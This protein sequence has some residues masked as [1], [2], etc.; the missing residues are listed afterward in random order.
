MDP[1]ANFNPLYT[2]RE[3]ARQIED[4]GATIMV[5]CGCLEEAQGERSTRALT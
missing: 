1:V 4:S 3:I 5:T 2:E